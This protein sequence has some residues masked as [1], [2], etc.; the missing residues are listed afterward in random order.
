MPDMDNA[1]HDTVLEV[2]S[3]KARLAKVYAE[4]LLAS[5]SR[6]NVAQPLGEELVQFVGGVLE[7]A[8]EIE[9]FLASPVVGKK[10]KASVLDAALPGRVSDLMRGLFTVLSQNGRLYLLRGIATIYAQLLDERAGRIP[11]KVSS[12]VALSESQKLALMAAL[13][14]ILKDQPV[15]VERVDPDLI[16]GLVIQV[17]DRVIDTSVRTRLLSLRTRL[18]ETP[19]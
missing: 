11:V 9:S 10:A 8:P 3:I 18:L 17:G 6:Q 5:A 15:L 19:K 16:G 1:K 7:A 12:A 4:A 13:A 2:G 14:G